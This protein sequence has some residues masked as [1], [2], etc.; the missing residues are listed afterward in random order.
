MNSSKSEI[1]KII[2]EAEKN[3]NPKIAISIKLDADIYMELKKRASKGE[4]RGKYQTLLNNLLRDSLFSNNS[5]E[6]RLKK[7]EQKLF[8]QA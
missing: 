1:D 5:I 3:K 8:K 4:A 6:E 2:E 7:I